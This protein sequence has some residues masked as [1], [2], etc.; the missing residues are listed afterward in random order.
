MVQ[1][2]FENNEH[3]KVSED[4]NEHN[5]CIKIIV[6]LIRGDLK[7]LQQHWCNEWMYLSEV[8]VKSICNL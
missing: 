6:A 5:N 7:T 3:I 1:A 2:L 4:P 8:N